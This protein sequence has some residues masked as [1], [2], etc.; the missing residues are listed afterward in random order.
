MNK[1]VQDAPYMKR[2]Y[3]KDFTELL[4]TPI[5]LALQSGSITV[6]QSSAAYRD[7]EGIIPAGSLMQYNPD[8]QMYEYYNGDFPAQGLLGKDTAVLDGNAHSF[9]YIGNFGVYSEMIPNAADNNGLGL[10]DVNAVA[11]AGR[12][13]FIKGGTAGKYYTPQ[14]VSEDGALSLDRP[15]DLDSSGGPLALSL[16][17]GLY[18]GQNKMIVMS[19]AGNAATLTIASHVTTSPESCTFDAVEEH[20][21]LQ[22]MGTKWRTVSTT[23][24]F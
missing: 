23:A 11:T 16:D 20:L 14:R 6:A 21:E 2:G 3:Q 10:F 9:L 22:W 5:G 17:D 8:T 7:E 24:S 18:I 19:V 13:T 1:T 15:S 4:I 12:G